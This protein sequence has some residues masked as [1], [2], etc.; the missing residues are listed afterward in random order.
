MRRADDVE[1]TVGI[2]GRRL[3]GNAGKNP[4]VGARDEDV[5][6]G[7]DAPLRNELWQQPLQPFDRS[8][9]VR[10][11]RADAI[12]PFGQQIGQRRQVALHRGALQPAL[13]NDL[14]KG[15]DADGDQE[16]D[17]EGRDRPAERGF[18]DQQAMIGRFRDRLRQSLDRIGL[19]ARARRVCARHAFDPLELLIV[20]RSREPRPLSNHSDL[21]PVFSALSRVNNSLMRN[22]SCP[23]ENRESE[24]ARSESETRTHNDCNRHCQRSEAIRQPRRKTGLLRRGVYRRAGERPDLLAPRNDGTRAS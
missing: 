22:K 15:A 3:D 11:D 14:D 7:G 1:N 8:G 16:G 6:S 20:T 19:D 10:P 21:N 4:S 24:S 9:A 2:A 5:A 18:R 17:D 23:G 12:E 13:V